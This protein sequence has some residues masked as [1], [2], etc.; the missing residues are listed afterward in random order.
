MT[1]TQRQDSLSLFL[2]TNN[3]ETLQNPPEPSRTLQN[4]PEPSRTLQNPPEPSSPL[5][6]PL[7]AATMA[8]SPSWPA[9]NHPRANPPGTLPLPGAAMASIAVSVIPPVSIATTSNGE[10]GRAG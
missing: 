6:P 2:S 10:A 9:G 3:Q 7:E 4:P 5:A 1:Y 8:A